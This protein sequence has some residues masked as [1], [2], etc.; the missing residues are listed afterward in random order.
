MTDDLGLII[1]SAIIGAYVVMTG[2]AS[3]LP[4]SPTLFSVALI[5]L[6]AVGILIQLG[7]FRR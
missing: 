3:L 7:L 4:I 2:F 5:L 6:I 1:L